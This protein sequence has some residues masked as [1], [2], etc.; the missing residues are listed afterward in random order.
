MGAETGIG[1]R[2]TTR[3]RVTI[4][5]VSDALG[6][7]KSTVSRALNG[8]PDISESTRARVRAMAER[9]GYRPLSHAQAIKTGRARSLGL[10]IQMAD[11]DAHRPFLAEFLA[12]IS[13][14]ASAE[15]WTLTVATS[16]S[17]ADT[18]EVMQNL[19]AD[20]KADGFILPRTEVRDARVAMLRDRHIPFVLF[21]R[22][23]D[24]EGCAWYDILGEEA[25]A[26]AVD[27]LHGQGHRRIGFVNGGRRYFYSL[28][29]REGFEGAMTRLGL[30][31]AGVVEDAVT[32]EAGAEATRTLLARKDPPTA[33]V[34]AVEAAAIGAYRAAAERGLTIGRDLS[35]ISYD[36]LSEGAKT[37]P[38]LTTFEVDFDTAGA[39]LSHLLIRRIRGEAPEDLR[40]T[41]PA[42][43]REGASDGPPPLAIQR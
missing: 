32:A 20:R 1:L 5:D 31:P 38:P 4:A 37:D 26:R 10:V 35:V 11:H 7:T 33:L 34:F 39:R 25:M 12:G 15:G 21:G 42:R 28:K 2:E 40:E 13:R 36:G 9:M 17:E 24:A 27:R 18:L 8:Y 43:L 3:T 29:R 22:T 23:A 19:T 16:T 6:L 14:G 30:T 41:V